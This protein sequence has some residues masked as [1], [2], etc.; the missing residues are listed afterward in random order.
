MK[1]IIKTVQRITYLCL[2][3]MILSCETDVTNDIDLKQSPPKLIINGGLERN[4]KSPLKSQQFQL[5]TTNDFLSKDPNP[6][7]SDA[8][9]SVTDG[10]TNY[11]FDYSGDGIYINDELE[12]TT[13][14]TYTVTIKWNGEVYEGSDTLNEVAPFDRFFAEFQEETVF[15]DEGYTLKCDTTDPAN[16]DNYY[17][18]RVYRNG[19]FVIKPDPGNSQ[20]LITSDEF[21]D[22]QKR[23][24]AEINGEVTFKVGDVAT[25]Q[26]L[27][28]SEG[29]FD[30]LFELFTQTGNTGISFGGNPPPATIRSNVINMTNPSNRAVGY[31]YTVDVAEDKLTITDE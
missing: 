16:V 23:I 6:F 22:G 24:G 10:T 13:G 18:Y 7:V 11:I 19:E 25:G 15:S 29:Y 2:S 3:I 21:F 28:I 1:A 17:Y 9:V 30:Y 4:S 26:Q 12:P 20:I 27:A 5:T 14:S 31:F 8:Q